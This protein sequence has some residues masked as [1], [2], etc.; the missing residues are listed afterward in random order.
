VS[1]TSQTTWEKCTSAL[2]TM[3]HTLPQHW[4]P[5]AMHMLIAADTMKRRE[6]LARGTSKLIHN[7]CKCSLPQRALPCL[8]CADFDYQ[9]CCSTG[10][11]KAS[12]HTIHHCARAPYVTIHI[13]I[14]WQARY[15]RRSSVFLQFGIGWGAQAS[16]PSIPAWAGRTGKP[17]VGKQKY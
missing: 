9:A 6:P 5:S 7:R 4:V 8:V 1:C 17:L 13:P 10:T 11:G 14:N 15:P 2:S 16:H 12:V 3:R